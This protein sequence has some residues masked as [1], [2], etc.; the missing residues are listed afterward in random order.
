[1]VGTEGSAQILGANSQKIFTSSYYINII[2]VAT[3]QG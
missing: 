2:A 3:I 1:M